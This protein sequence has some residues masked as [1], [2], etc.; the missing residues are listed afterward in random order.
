MLLGKLV[1]N[2][3]VILSRC[4]PL[5]LSCSCQAALIAVACLAVREADT[6]ALCI[7]G[8]QNEVLRSVLIMK[9]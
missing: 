5:S 9:L 4:R 8:R 3:H 6:R 1:R 7:C 2:L